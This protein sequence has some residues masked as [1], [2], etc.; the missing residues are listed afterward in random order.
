ME[1]DVFW[2]PLNTGDFTIRTA[3]LCPG[4][5]CAYILLLC[6]LSRH[7]YLPT[8]MREIRRIC[9][10]AEQPKV[11]AAMTLLDRDEKG[12]YS[13]EIRACQCKII[14][15]KVKRSLAGKAGAAAR[16]SKKDG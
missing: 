3:H 8:D 7:P 15:R 10:G 1:N 5:V 2:F 12:V 16:W 6:Y 14:T 13:A 11:V 4:G 9:R